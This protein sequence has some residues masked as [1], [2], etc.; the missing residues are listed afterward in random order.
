M[1]SFRQADGL[2]VES[3]AEL[4]PLPV[5]IGPGSMPVYPT[6]DGVFDT[7]YGCARNEEPPVERARIET[8]LTLKQDELEK[9]EKRRQRHEILEDASMDFFENLP[10]A[11]LNAFL[12]SREHELGPALFNATAALP[13][14]GSLMVRGKRGLQAGSSAVKQLPYYP[15][16]ATP[17]STSV[18]RDY[19]PGEVLKEIMP[20]YRQTGVL[21]DL[22]PGEREKLAE[23][24]V[25]ATTGLRSAMGKIPETRLAGPGFIRQTKV[26]GLGFFDLN[27]KKWLPALMNMRRAGKEAQA[28][29]KTH[30]LDLPEGWEMR[31]DV[32]KGNFKFD[33]NGNIKG[34]VDP[35]W[36]GHQDWWDYV[37]PFLWT[38]K[39]R[40]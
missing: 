13:L 19:G 21:V 6:T 4:P 10:P 30:P 24:M 38:Q 2:P 3:D 40:L 39:L 11:L 1:Q 28:W 17:G 25:T 27:W 8:A 16:I 9:E 5:A 34:W 36:I 26:E 15:R 7:A 18:V 23:L 22:K 12:Y 32:G 31:I 33:E 35:F 29:A 14:L 37:H 20:I